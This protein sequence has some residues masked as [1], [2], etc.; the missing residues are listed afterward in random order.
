MSDK[1]KIRPAT[2]RDREFSYRVA[3]EAMRT[4][5]EATYGEWKDEWQRQYHDEEFS[6]SPPEVVSIDGTDVGIWKV[7]REPQRLVLKKIYLLPQFQRRGLGTSLI[8][9]LIRES[10]TCGLPI[11]LRYLKVN[12][13]GSLYERLGFMK[14]KEEGP[15]VYVRK[16][17]QPHAAH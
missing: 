4:Y 17:L 16:A 8:Q 15:H 10:E 9:H 3:K 14:I 11:E 5:V 12:P 2:E 1:V 7:S 6:S 13:V